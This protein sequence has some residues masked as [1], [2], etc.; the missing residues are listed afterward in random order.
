[1]K[2]D[3]ALAPGQ[4]GVIRRYVGSIRKAAYG[5]NEDWGNGFGDA[6]DAVVAEALNAPDTDQFVAGLSASMRGEA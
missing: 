6:V 3:K 2:K 4:Y 1:M 5:P